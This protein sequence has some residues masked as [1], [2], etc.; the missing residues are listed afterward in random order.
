MRQIVENLSLFLYKEKPLKTPS[1]PLCGKNSKKA[2]HIE[3]RAH[4]SR[5]NLR[6]QKPHVSE[7]TQKSRRKALLL[8]KNGGKRKSTPV[9]Q[10]IRFIYRFPVQREYNI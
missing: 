4:T 8:K 6:E 7:K 10:F 3:N 5:E 9:V 2:R 1:R